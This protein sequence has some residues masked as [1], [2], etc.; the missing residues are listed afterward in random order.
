MRRLRKISLAVLPHLIIIVGVLTAFG[1][2]LDVE[3]SFA[4]L[5]GGGL[6]ASIFYFCTCGSGYLTIVIGVPGTT[7]G[8]YL[9]S[10]ATQY[11]VGTGFPSAYWLGFY[12]PGAG[13]CPITIGYGCITLTGS[14][15]NYYGGS[16]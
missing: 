12:T 11:W 16:I 3:V 4:Q 7:S 2:F 10:S 9:F 6:N 1:V 14:L 13:I 15:M 5:A 8:L